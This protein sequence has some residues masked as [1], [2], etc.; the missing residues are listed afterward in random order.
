MTGEASCYGKKIFPSYWSAQRSA[1]DLNKHRDGAKANPYKCDTCKFF[2]VGN[3][4]GH[5]KHRRPSRHTK[6]GIARR[7]GV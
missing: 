3:T 5:M 1:R 6:K 4:M 2:H 7:G